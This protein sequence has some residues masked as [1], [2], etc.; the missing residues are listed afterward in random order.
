VTPSTYFYGVII[1]GNWT[2]RSQDHSLPGAKVP[3]VELSLPGTVVSWNFRS[4]Q[5]IEH[6]TTGGIFTGVYPEILRSIAESKAKAIFISEIN[7]LDEAFIRKTN[8]M[9][10]NDPLYDKLKRYHDSLLKSVTNTTRKNYHRKCLL[11]SLTQLLSTTARDNF[12]G[13]KMMKKG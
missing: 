9:K 10:Q 8:T 1:R 4:H 7:A 13:L 2:F 6:G 11:L 3:D 12:A 5:Q